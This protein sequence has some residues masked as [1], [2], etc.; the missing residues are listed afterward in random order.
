MLE[1]LRAW[2]NGSQDYSIGAVL[3]VKY[4]DNEAL[5]N[6][7]M[8]GKTD[9]LVSRLKRELLAIYHQ[10]KEKEDGSAIHT[11]NRIF[12]KDNV[13]SATGD[14][15]DPAPVKI[16][17]DG[18]KNTLLYES[19][20]QQAH[21]AYK[22]CMNKRAV[23]FSLIPGEYEAANPPDL[24]ESRKKLAIEVVQLSHDYS[25]L[26]DRAD[27][28]K[29]HGVLPPEEQKVKE[30]DIDSIPDIKVKQCLDNLRKA[31]SKLRGREQT[32]DRISLLQ[33]HESNIK[34]LE[35]RWHLLQQ[36]KK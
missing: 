26:Y 17:S 36:E 7:L 8:A 11:G 25:R 10:L 14:L 28:V 19:C 35:E 31:A 16:A 2:L 4:G 20:I 23:L 21:K 27:Y 13:N 32:P 29:L 30:F 33:Q 1:N 9:Y 5:K 18:I 12:D 15:T 3:Y 34:L 6:L 22:E 24:I